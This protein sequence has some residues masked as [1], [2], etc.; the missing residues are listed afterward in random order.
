MLRN[1]LRTYPFK[2]KKVLAIE[3]I[4]IYG[5]NTITETKD[6]KIYFDYD[7]YIP[8]PTL[9][10]KVTPIIKDSIQ[11]GYIIINNIIE[12]PLIINQELADSCWLPNELLED[13][14]RSVKANTD[15]INNLTIEGNLTQEDN[16]L[17]AYQSANNNNYLTKIK[18]D[19]EYIE[20]KNIILNGTNLITISGSTIGT[21]IADISL[22]CP[23]MFD[24]SLKGDPGDQ[25]DAGENGVDGA[26]IKDYQFDPNPCITECFCYP[27]ASWCIN[28]Y[29]NEVCQVNSV[30]DQEQ[31]FRFASSINGS[32][33]VPIIGM[34]IG[35]GGGGG[36]CDIDNTN[37]YDVTLD[38]AG[39]CILSNMFPN[40]YEDEATVR[41]RL[42]G[43]PTPHKW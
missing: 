34:D 15:Y 16:M 21:T 26:S 33:N 8:I 10:N 30:V 7:F 24:N 20:G 6:N 13:G 35:G 18:V 19:G 22:S 38:I 25:G 42:F 1:L 23:T 36:G 40:S 31:N 41:Q 29:S 39:D 27:G 2:Y 37:T 11:I 17:H 9:L 28:P 14:V 32:V 12:Q 5:Y 43:L 4:F 3:D